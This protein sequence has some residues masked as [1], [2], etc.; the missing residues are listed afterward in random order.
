M[1]AQVVIDISAGELDRTF[2]YKIPDGL[3]VR[4][5][6]R[7]EVPFGKN[8]KEGFVVGF[9]ET[10]DFPD[11]LKE[12]ITAPDGVPAIL[13]EMLELMEK[14][15]HKYLLRRADIIRLFA[16]ERVRAGKKPLN[17]AVF[18]KVGGLQKQVE[19]THEQ[20]QALAL[21]RGEGG[22]SAIVG[23]AKTTPV[24]PAKFLLH[25]VT[26]SGKTELYMRMIEDAL[27]QGKSAIM[28]VPEISLTPQMLSN[29]RGRF[30]KTVALLH[31]GLSAGER[32]S[33]WLRLRTGDA[34]IA[35]GPRSAVF[36]PLENLGLIVVDEEHDGSYIS[37]SNPRYDTLEVAEMRCGLASAKL[38]LGSAT[39]AVGT[40]KRAAEGEL[41]LVKLQNRVGG[42]ALPGPEIVD[43]AAELRAGNNGIFSKLAE[44]A[45]ATVIE[46]K[47]QAVIFLNRRGF[48]SFMM[49]KACGYIAM[50]ADCDISLTFH[51]EDNTLK[52][53]YC[54]KKYKALTACPGCKN[55]KLKMGRVGTQ[56]VAEELQRLFPGVRIARLD[57]DSTTG[58]TAYFDILGAFSRGEADLLVG[59]QMV[60]K[61]HDFPAVSLALV[62]D[63]DMGL[64]FQDYASA[65][66]TYQLI[67]QV[68]GR[69]G[70]ADG[71][72]RVIIQ[73]YRPSHYVF[74]FA[75][76]YDYNG[77]YEKEINTRE[78]TKFPPFC[79][80]AR[81]LCSSENEDKA[82]KAAKTALEQAK[83]IRA[84]SPKDF[85]ALTSMRAPVGR[86]K[87]AHRFQ[88][89][90]RVTSGE[91]VQRLCQAAESAKLKGV[92]VFV[93]INP[94]SLY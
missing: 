29:F 81:I 5:G 55:S 12:I 11:K 71:D 37:E 84:E 23:P 7:V 35:L 62:L 21:L 57:N 3:N 75:A 28:L 77:F 74:R 87:R 15:R 58:K 92:S 82:L 73:T 78:V 83:A 76:N 47:R 10:T 79:I 6:E 52:C 42:G 26:G 88:I 27:T 20:Q 94:Q 32:Q 38:I 22:S 59:T 30:G 45:L 86:I 49:C 89:I 66:R 9:A 65:E 54:G 34:R 19:L 68:A 51:S 61:G 41:T 85:I 67:T 17:R 13:P 40:Y 46:R 1:I 90:A 91:T 80:I 44:D 39:P 4:L 60:A 18:D 72:G 93:E 56:R 50:C 43:M 2:D 48:A 25:G 24:N 33:E 70:R 53:H 8:K 16:P 31:S 64:Y 63:A 14:M 69:S 36:A